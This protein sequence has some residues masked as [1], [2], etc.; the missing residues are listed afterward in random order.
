MRVLPADL[1]A[2]QEA[3]VRRP[4][5]K[6]LAFDRSQDSISAIVRVNTP[7]NLST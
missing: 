6:V 5:Y 2:A 1:E 4:A 7:R 3:V